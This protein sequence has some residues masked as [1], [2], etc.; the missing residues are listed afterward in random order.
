M[1]GNSRRWALQILLLG[2]VGIGLCQGQARDVTL[3][4]SLSPHRITVGDPIEFRVL[5]HYPKGTKISAFPELDFGKME[6]LS[7]EPIEATTEAGGKQQQ[8]QSFRITAF[9]PGDFETPQVEVSYMPADS[10]EAQKVSCEASSITVT[11]VLTDQAQDLRDI[12]QPL[13]V[14]A[15]A[16]RWWLWLIPG[17][18][19]LAL[20]WWLWKKRVRPSESREE[21]SRPALPPYQEA[22]AALDH[23]ESRKLPQQGESKRHY[24]ELSEIIRRYVQRVFEIPARELTS[25]E[26]L[27]GLRSKSL[28]PE[29]LDDLRR[30]LNEADLVKFAKWV[31]EFERDRC[32]LE[33][34]RKWLQATRPALAVEEPSGSEIEEPAT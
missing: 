25:G 9:E 22:V 18:V 12:K 28:S 23:L 19:L 26:I 27:A 13:E 17:A 20:A 8:G 3:E 5:V 33:L 7:R 29:V 16:S 10:Q 31:P 24:I 1:R 30:L 6:L 34:T 4:C 32:L 11:S 21:V 14:P 15:E 2:G